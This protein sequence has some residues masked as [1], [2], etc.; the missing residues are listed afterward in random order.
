MM[1]GQVLKSEL[2]TV[3]LRG[4]EERGPVENANVFVAGYLWADETAEVVA[5]QVERSL[6]L[7]IFATLSG[8]RRS[9]NE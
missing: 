5:A 9:P 8:P 3:L 6:K 1:Y 4:V 7:S 2:V